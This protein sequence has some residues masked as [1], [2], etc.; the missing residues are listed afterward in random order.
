VISLRGKEE[1]DKIEIQKK[2]IN[3]GNG[4][5]QKVEREGGG[6]THG[7]IAVNSTNVLSLFSPFFFLFAPALRTRSM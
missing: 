4:G 6:N 7:D 5:Q 2:K 1:K 3:G